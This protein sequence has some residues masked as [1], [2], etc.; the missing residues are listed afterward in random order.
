MAAA[1]PKKRSVVK[2]TKIKVGLTLAAVGASIGGWSA[3]GLHSLDSGTS[4]QATGV[5]QAAQVA[6]ATPTTAAPAHVAAVVGAAT[7]P[8]TTAAQSST[9]S[10]STTSIRPMA[11]TRASR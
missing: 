6:T 9:S 5:R 1:N 8:D 10:Q 3:L 4:A 11:R 2:T 7:V